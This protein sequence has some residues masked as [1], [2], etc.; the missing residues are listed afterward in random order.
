MKTHLAL[1]P[2]AT[3]LLAL[4]PSTASAH[5]VG[6]GGHA[7]PEKP[8]PV[9]VT[10]CGTHAHC[11][12]TQVWV[13]KSLQLVKKQ[14][15]VP[16]KPHQ[17]WIPPVYQTTYGYGGQPCTVLVQ[18]GHH[19]TE[20]TPGHFKTVSERVVVPGH[21]EAA[22]KPL[23]LPKLGHHKVKAPHVGVFGKAKHGG[24]ELQVHAAKDHGY[25]G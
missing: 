18:P 5:V 7:H 15:W 19:V 23:L 8:K 4:A 21:Y 3:L 13:P 16:A 10:G 24:F 25:G 17:V 20:W 11:V 22:C 14:V 1:A 9:P 12:P 6:V 2:L